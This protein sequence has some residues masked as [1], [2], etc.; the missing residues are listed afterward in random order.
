M[1]VTTWPSSPPPGVLERPLQEAD[2]QELTRRHVLVPWAA[3]GSLAHPV[4]DHARGSWLYGPGGKR[5]LDFSSGLI[6]VN[7]GHA[8][9]HV[10]QAIERQARRVTYV[11]PN[12]ATDVRAELARKLAVRSPGG[13]LTRVF[14][15]VGGAEANENAIKIARMVTGRH[16]VLA[17]YRSYHGGTYGASTLSGESRRWPAEPG[18]PGVVHF[19]GPYPY[20]SPFRVPPEQEAEAALAHLEE[21]LHYEGPHTVAAVFLEP[22]VGSNGLIVPPDG[23]LQGVRRLC[24]RFGILLVLDE[25]MTGFGR[26]GRWFAAEHWNVVP[27]MI[28]F[29]KGV[30]AGYVPLGG[31]LVHERLA[32]H[33][34]QQVLWAGLTYSGHPL[35]CAAGVATMEVYEQEGLV[36]RAARLE[37]VV[38]HRLEE[39]ARRHPIVGDVR[40]KGL[41]FGV[42][43]VR[44][45]ATREAWAAWNSPQTGPMNRLLSALLER[46]VYLFGR[47]NV[48]FIAPPLTITEEELDFGIEALGEVLAR[49][50]QEGWGR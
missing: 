26:T 49:A 27:D 35:A 8:H 32:R 25:V 40:G 37:P 44:D 45:R 18:I 28:T 46:G 48:L 36:E 50:E 24:D 29:A 15:T 42:E 20:R 34:D 21:V 11:V 17:A 30:T 12:F 22:I 10:V 14:F 9:P 6:N 33:F 47:W 43:L 7:I 23:Y 4:V 5:W 16:K 13:Q 2:V 19:F 31:V 41:F 38:R 39:L 1:P 3:Q